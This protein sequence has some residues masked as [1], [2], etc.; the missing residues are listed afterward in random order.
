MYQRVVGQINK[1]PTFQSR[2]S[3]LDSDMY[4]TLFCSSAQI[5]I[6]KCPRILLAAFLGKDEDAGRKKTRL[7]QELHEMYPRVPVLRK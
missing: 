7:P 2:E 1:L 4:V 6:R 3:F 5:G